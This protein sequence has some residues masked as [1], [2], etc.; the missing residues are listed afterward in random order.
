MKKALTLLSLSAGLSPAALLVTPTGITYTTTPNQEE[1]LNL[2]DENNI[3]NGN[4]LSGTPDFANYTSITHAA[5]SFDAPGNAWATID[6]GPA[7]GDFYP[8]GGIAPVFEMT[9][10]EVYELTDF[11]YWGYYFDSPNGNEGR[12]FL[13][14]FSTDGG[15][16]FPTSTTVSSPLGTLAFAN[17][18]TLPLGGSFDA[19]A[20][21]MTIT[22]NHF[23]GPAGGDR[24]GMGE[25]RFVAI[26][27]PSSA[28][29]GSLALIGLLRRRR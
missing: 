15:S 1:G 26:P 6:P 22:D 11:V 20:V 7:A 10:D 28:I 27:E 24:V 16:T 29:L 23:G 19:N 3:I 5:V 13:L 21:R 14:E 25:V 8:Q 9:L 12:E 2:G 4:G 17:A 18:L